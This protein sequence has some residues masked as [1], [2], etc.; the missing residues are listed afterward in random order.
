MPWRLDSHTFAPACAANTPAMRPTG[1]VPPNTT[2]FKS[3]RPV[4]WRFNSAA[5]THATIAAAVV[6]E[7]LG[8]AISETTNGLTMAL[9]AR[10]SMSAASSTSRP[11]RKMPVRATPLGPREKIVSWVRPAIASRPTSL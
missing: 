11:P 1:P 4:A 9:R 3:A 6:N 8:S 2:T 10:S 5:S 7:P